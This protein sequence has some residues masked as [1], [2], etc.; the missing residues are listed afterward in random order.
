MYISRLINTWRFFKWSYQAA[1]PKQYPQALLYSGPKEAAI[2]FMHQVLHRVFKNASI[3]LA[4]SP[5][6]TQYM[7]KENVIK[8]NSNYTRNECGAQAWRAWKPWQPSPYTLT[9]QKWRS[10]SAP[11]SVTSTVWEVF[12]SP[13]VHPFVM[14]SEKLVFIIRLPRK[15]LDVRSVFIPTR[16]DVYILCLFF[17]AALS[18]CSPGWV[19]MADMWNR[20]AVAVGRMFTGRAH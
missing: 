3:G 1:V 11:G 5:P 13:H 18:S 10:R 4:P 7:L 9:L 2:N 17:C 16:R 19:H 14:G 15:A 20:C 8:S 6:K 12:R